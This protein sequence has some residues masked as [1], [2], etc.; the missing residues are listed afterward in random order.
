[1]LSLTIAFFSHF[2]TCSLVRLP[3]ASRPHVRFFAR[4]RL[5]RPA[6]QPPC[7][8]DLDGLTPHVHLLLSLVVV[9][10]R[11]VFPSLSSHLPPAQ[12]P[13]SPLGYQAPGIRLQGPAAS[14]LALFCLCCLHHS[15]HHCSLSL[16]SRLSFLL[17]SQNFPCVSVFFL[18]LSFSSSITCLASLPL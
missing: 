6:P 9:V 7:I 16:V 1:M 11:W 14:G 2:L 15:L 3:N 8:V 17:K 12:V 13:L 5:H 10:S 4:V 18:P